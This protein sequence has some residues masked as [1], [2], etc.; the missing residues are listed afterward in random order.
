MSFSVLSGNSV[1]NVFS[2]RKIQ[3]SSL[4]CLGCQD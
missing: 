4:S 3:L 1:V 2:P